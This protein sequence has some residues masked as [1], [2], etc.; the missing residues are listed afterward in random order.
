[1]TIENVCKCTDIR[2]VSNAKQYHKLVNKSNF[3]GSKLFD[4]DNP[5]FAVHMKQKVITLI[6][7]TYIGSCVL[8]LSKLIMYKFHYEWVILKYGIDAKLLFTD[9]G[10]LCYCINKSTNTYS[11]IYINKHLFDLSG[12]PKEC[13]YYN[14]ENMRVLW[15]MKDEMSGRTICRFTIYNV[16][17]EIWE[18][19]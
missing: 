8:E 12:L 9:T 18:W 1:M 13:K 17:I 5:M 16:V 10:S 3:E 19:K 14:G 6:M 11:D 4:D 2:L 7:P 15:K